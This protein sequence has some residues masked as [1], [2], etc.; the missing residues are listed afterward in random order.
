MVIAD[1]YPKFKMFYS[2]EKLILRKKNVS[3]HWEI[4]VSCTTQECDKDTTTYIYDLSSGRLQEV[5]KE[6]KISYF[7]SKSDRGCL[8]ELVG[9]KRFQVQWFD[10]ETFGIL[11]NCSLRR[12]GRNRRFHCIFF[13]NAY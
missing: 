7:S 6:K 5:K 9:Y 2:C 11:L 3:S 10:L 1:T 8:R 13:V 12:D 4:S